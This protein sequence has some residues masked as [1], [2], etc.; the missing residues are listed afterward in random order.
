MISN[1]FFV[2][3]SIGLV[4][5]GTGL[6]W[7]G[8]FGFNAG[9]ALSAGALASVAFANTTIAPAAAGLVWF[10][11][12]LAVRRNGA[13]LVAAST[14][15]VIGLVA[16]TPAAGYVVP[17]YSIIIGGVTAAFGYGML[18]LKRRLQGMGSFFGFDDTLDAFAVHGM[19]GALGSFFTGLFATKSINPSG[20]DGAFY[21]NPSLLGWQMVAILITIIIS[22]G[23]TAILLGIMKAIPWFG[24]RAT[25]EEEFAGLDRTFHKEIIDTYDFADATELAASPR[26]DRPKILDQ[27][28]LAKQKVYKTREEEDAELYPSIQ[29]RGFKGALTRGGPEEDTAKKTAQPARNIMDEVSSDSDDEESEDGTPLTSKK[30]AAKSNNQESSSSSDSSDSESES[31]SVEV[32]PVSKKVGKKS[33]PA[34][35]A[36]SKK[37]SSK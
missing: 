28:N 13:S 29:K 31:S 18:W 5:T 24:V 33:T 20:A 35:K 22:F 17:G 23:L 8:W 12:D 15:V 14:G 10:L 2:S 1:Y 16:I 27:S 26:L 30:A 9:S 11:L 3:C 34:Q 25:G 19:G 32:K 36:K 6:L 37:P 21:G 7:V 4:L